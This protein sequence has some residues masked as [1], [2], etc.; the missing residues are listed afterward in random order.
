MTTTQTA[1]KFQLG[2]RVV[3]LDGFQ[4][5]VVKVTQWE[6]S[7]WYDVRLGRAGVAV[8]YTSDLKAA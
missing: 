5:T 8:R 7:T 4:G 1:P 6:G 2:Q 3:D